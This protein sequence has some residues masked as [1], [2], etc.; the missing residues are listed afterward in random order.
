MDALAPRGGS[1][2][3]AMR[4]LRGLSVRRQPAIIQAGWRREA[5]A[6][7]IRSRMTSGIVADPGA[8]ALA[9]CVYRVERELVRPVRAT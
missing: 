7:G 8:I 2:R 4:D 9:A 6:L 5:V 3:Q 1:V